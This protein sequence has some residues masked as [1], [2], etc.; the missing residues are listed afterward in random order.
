MRNTLFAGLLAASLLA[1]S[2]LPALAAEDAY[3]L[4]QTRRQT[5]ADEA[6]DMDQDMQEIRALVAGVSSAILPGFGQWVF[7]QQRPKAV[8]HFIGAVALWS[9][10]AFV[11]IPS[12]LD[13]LYM[14]IPS[15]FHLYSG[16]DAYQGAGGEMKIV[17]QPALAAWSFDRQV[18]SFGEERPLTHLSL[19]S[20]TLAD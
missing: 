10:P 16:Y 15:L 19:A 8:I 20:A 5:T 7:N 17:Q 12:P 1:G 2:T 11:T 13:R 9:L 14:A 6:D 3:Q 4:A 18:A